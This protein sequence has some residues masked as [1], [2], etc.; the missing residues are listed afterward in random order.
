MAIYQP[1][2]ASGIGR[3]NS[4]RHRASLEDLSFSNQADISI[5][6]ISGAT[7]ASEGRGDCGVGEVL[8]SSLI[9]NSA[10]RAAD[11]GGLRRRK[12]PR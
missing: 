12:V 7:A 9:T 2:K 4:R 3:A 8:G 6:P 11:K 1:V 5:I 10:A